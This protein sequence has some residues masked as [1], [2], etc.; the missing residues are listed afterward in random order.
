MNNLPTNFGFSFSSVN[1]Y[2]TCPQSF[3][4]TYLDKVHRGSSF[5]GEYGSFCHDILQK[6]FEGN[7]D[8]FELADY[9]KKNYYENVKT[10]PPPFIKNIHEDYYEKGLSFFEEFDF[11]KE[12]Y[13]IINVEEFVRGNYENI[14]FVMK[15]DLILIDKTTTSVVLLDYKTA[16]LWKKGVFNKKKMQEYKVQMNLYIYF[17]RK[18]K[19]LQINKV[20][21]WF[22]RNNK[23]EEWD[24]NAEDEAAAL[25]W[26][27]NVAREI[28]L[29]TDWHP[30]N[31]KK[32][33]FFCQH[34]CSV[35]SSC[36]YK[37]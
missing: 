4:L 20:I 25:E 32:N 2:L 23:F 37:P 5:W 28:T 17:L 19:G 10:S 15:P 13:E 36:E 9:Y 7:L 8:I 35:S 14:G 6:Y 33:A 30:N 1:T 26:F 3:K 27:I 16:D 12:K 31:D 11:P 21:L 29:N 18:T 24:Y 22:L 34:L